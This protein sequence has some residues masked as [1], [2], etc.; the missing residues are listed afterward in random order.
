[1]KKFLSSYWSV[2][3]LLCKSY[4]Y[5]AGSARG[6]DEANP[7]LWL[8]TYLARSGLIIFPVLIPRKKKRSWSWLAKLVT[9][10]QCW[11][12]SRKKRQKT[13]KTKQKKLN[14]PLGFIVLQAQLAGF[15]GSQNKQVILDS[16]KS[17]IFFLY[18]KSFTDRAERLWKCV[19]DYSKMWCI[20]RGCLF[21][22]GL[23]LND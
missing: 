10:G 21:P 1:M 7:L 22:Q 17:E 14:D 4:H 13:V 16:Y 8:A 20:A 2:A 19:A 3:I 12:R 6:Q 11:R 23:G 15:L 18:N 5:I 9:F